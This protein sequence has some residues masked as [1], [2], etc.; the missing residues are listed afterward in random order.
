MLSDLFNEYVSNLLL[1]GSGY[2]G[3]APPPTV[4]QVD[5]DT[6]AT[7]I[8]SAL[9]ALLSRPVLHWVVV[10]PVR[11][12]GTGGVLLVS[13]GRHGLKISFGDGSLAIVDDTFRYDLALGGIGDAPFRIFT[14]GVQF[15]SADRIVPF[16]SP[17]SLGVGPLDVF[18][19]FH[20]GNDLEN[21]RPLSLL[22][23][24]SV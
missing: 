14:P 10:T 11:P 2:C 17:F 13:R 3:D 1:P 12:P 23:E 18:R 19:V 16:L 9:L 8:L 7:A 15:P 20:A 6:V 5:V 21:H 24:G 22:P 4:C